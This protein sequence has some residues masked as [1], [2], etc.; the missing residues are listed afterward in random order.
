M[1]QK[2]GNTNIRKKGAVYGVIAAMLCLAVYLNW[3]YVETPDE[4]IVANQASAAGETDLLSYTD[5]VGEEDAAAEVVAGSD[6]FAQSR[7]SREKARDEA[8][9]ILKDSLQ[10]DS[11]TEDDRQL[12]AAQI[13]EYAD[14]SVAEARIE[15]LIKAK[16]YPEAVVFLSDD[17]V[18]VI[19][20][21]KADAIESADAALIQDIVTSETAYTVAQIRIVEAAV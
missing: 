17:G 11:A 1:V 4:L 9:S 20:K 16:G 6:Y 7:L 15:S 12:A 14:R 18:N 13:S 19:V 3:S 21:P 10:S 8:I 2:K 5:T